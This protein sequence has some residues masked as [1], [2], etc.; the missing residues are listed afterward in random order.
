LTRLAT[1]RLPSIGTD[2][3]KGA[4]AR[5][6]WRRYAAAVAEKRGVAAADPRLLEQNASA[7]HAGYAFD[8]KRRLEA[9]VEGDPERLRAMARARRNKRSPRA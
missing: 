2:Q 8:L 6:P 1:I 9:A 4:R 3:A 7:R 5:G